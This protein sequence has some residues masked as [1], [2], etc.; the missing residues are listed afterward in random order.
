[1]R[2]PFFAPEI[3]RGKHKCHDVVA[4]GAEPA[5]SFGRDNDVAV[6]RHATGH[7]F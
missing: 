1:M 6:T 4:L 3:I 5:V 7:I 2:P